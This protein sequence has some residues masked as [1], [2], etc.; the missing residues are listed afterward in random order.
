MRPYRYPHFQ[1]A[2][3]EKIIKELL[4]SGVVRHSTS[5]FSSPILFVKK[6]D[7]TWRMCVDYRAL[8]AATIKD[9][10]P[11]PMIDELLNETCG[12][13]VYTKLDL[14]SGYHQIRMKPESVSKTAFWTHKGHEFL[15]M[16]FGLTNA[17][18]TFQALMNE[19]F[20]ELL[21]KFVFVFFDD[22]LTYS[23]SMDE[24]IEH[25]T[26]VFEKLQQH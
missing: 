3:I 15:I 2:E 17:L 18:S 20:R 21:R 5:P 13:V 12:S 16:P 6:K 4:G 25:L 9:K 26:K 8:N 7:G 19:I 1:K 22:I 10:F 11:I 14:R 23:K 24:H